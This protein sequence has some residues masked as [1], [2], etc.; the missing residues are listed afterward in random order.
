[1][2]SKHAWVNLPGMGSI[3]LTEFRRSHHATYGMGKLFNRLL[4]ES[5]WSKDFT[6]ELVLDKGKGCLVIT[7]SNISGSVE[8]HDE[9]MTV[10]KVKEIL[11]EVLAQSHG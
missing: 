2:H 6:A 7:H 5:T 10:E 11:E 9:K 3:S 8:I 1:M 4:E